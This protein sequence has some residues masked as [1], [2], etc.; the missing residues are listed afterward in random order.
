VETSEISG[1]ANGKQ[2]WF[3]SGQVVVSLDNVYRISGQYA[4]S[5]DFIGE[6]HGAFT[7]VTVELTPGSAKK[8]ADLIQTALSRG[9][10]GGILAEGWRSV[11]QNQGDGSRSD[12]ANPVLP[13]GVK[14]QV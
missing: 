14:V 13:E 2:G 3:K 9:I 6:S 12:E 4:V 10:K 7:K 5:L 1:G 8:L 11:V